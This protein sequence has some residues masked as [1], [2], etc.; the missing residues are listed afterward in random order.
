MPPLFLFLLSGELFLN[1]HFQIIQ[2]KECFVHLSG[3]HGRNH[4][5]GTVYGTAYVKTQ[6][7]GI[8][9]FLLFPEDTTCH[10]TA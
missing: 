3:F 5:G 8:E 4:I 10:Q 9:L 7:F 6:V 1:G 2:Y